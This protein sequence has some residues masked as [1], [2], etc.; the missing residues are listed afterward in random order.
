MKN[1]ILV[2]I[3]VLSAIGSFI[4]RVQSGRRAVQHHPSSWPA[5]DHRFARAP[6]LHSTVLRRPRRSRIG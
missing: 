3:V 2:A 1:V 6:S 4:F 5:A